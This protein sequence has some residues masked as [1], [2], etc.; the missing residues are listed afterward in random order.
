MIEWKRKGKGKGN[1][2]GGYVG[3]V[4]M[5]EVVMCK[6][7]RSILYFDQNPNIILFHFFFFFGG[8]YK[9]HK[10][11]SKSNSVIKHN[12]STQ[13]EEIKIQSRSFYQKKPSIALGVLVRGGL[14]IC[15]W[16]FRHCDCY[17]IFGVK[18]AKIYARKNLWYVISR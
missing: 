12:T 13:K 5:T 6:E 11:Y 4:T 9:I 1:Q 2:D 10:R 8:A 3:F 7:R 15:V 18:E 17:V 14:G 16:V